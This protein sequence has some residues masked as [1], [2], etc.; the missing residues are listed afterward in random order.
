MRTLTCY[1]S[2]LRYYKVSMW[3]YRMFANI[4]SKIKSKQSKVKTD[5]TNIIIFKS[6]QTQCSMLPMIVSHK[7]VHKKFL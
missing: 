6:K 4:N 7:V 5:I 2:C 3:K 1:A